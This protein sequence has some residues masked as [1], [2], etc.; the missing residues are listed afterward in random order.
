[1]STT[2]AASYLTVFNE[3]LDPGIFILSGCSILCN[4]GL[5]LEL[6]LVFL[7]CFELLVKF[8][9]FAPQKV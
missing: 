3:K 8:F 4:S 5:G 2:K 9:I 1:M 6:Q 7:R